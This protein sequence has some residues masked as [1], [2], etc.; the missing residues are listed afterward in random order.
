M[1]LLS[2]FSMLAFA[3]LPLVQIGVH[4]TLSASSILLVHCRTNPDHHT[5]RT[6]ITSIT[7]LGFDSTFLQC[8]ASP[9]CLDHFS[10]LSVLVLSHMFPSLFHL[11]P[12]RMPPLTHHSS[13]ILFLDLI[14]TPLC[15]CWQEDP[16]ILDYYATSYCAQ[17]SSPF[18]TFFQLEMSCD[19]V[20]I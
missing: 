18:T 12:P 15:H 3:P 4:C 19:G 2:C 1:L 9:L 8:L 14:L 13:P 7:Y 11:P 20:P 10:L 17:F 6:S 16:S 5:T